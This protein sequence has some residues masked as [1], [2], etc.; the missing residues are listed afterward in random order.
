MIQKSLSMLEKT[1]I[2]ISSRFINSLSVF[3]SKLIFL[4]AAPIKSSILKKELNSLISKFKNHP[5]QVISLLSIFT[6]A[7]EIFLSMILGDITRFLFVEL[8][9]IILCI[10]GLFIKSDF[11]SIVKNS[12]IFNAI[13]GVLCRL[14]H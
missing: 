11:E 3:A 4:F 14:L 10:F 6:F 13:E 8:F 9:L 5:V 1:D 2:F 12:R 7:T